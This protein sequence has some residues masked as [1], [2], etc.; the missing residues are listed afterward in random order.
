MWELYLASCEISFRH[1]GPMVFQIQLAQDQH[2]LPLTRGYMF[3][4]ERTN[5]AAGARAAE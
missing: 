3:D 4:W 1:Q 2:R 5:G